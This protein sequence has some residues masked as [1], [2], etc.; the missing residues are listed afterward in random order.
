VRAVSP[1]RIVAPGAPVTFAVGHLGRSRP[2][3]VVLWRTDL[4][5]AQPVA[6]GTIAA[7]RRAW[8]WDGRVGGAPAP[9]GTYLAQLRRADSAGNLARVPAQIPTRARSP[10]APGVTVRALAA[11]PPVGPVTAGDRV[12]VDVDSRRRPYTWRLRRLGR[13]GTVARGRAGGTPL[14]LAA[15]AGRSGV[16]VLTLRTA[17]AATRVPILVQSQRRAKLLVVVPMLS[18]LAG[19]RVDDG[20]DGQ[21]DTLERGGPVR[22]PRVLPSLP[23]ELRRDVGPLLSFLDRSRVP[24]DLTSDL[25]LALGDGPRASDRPGVLL[26]GAERWI[27]LA[28]G[29]RLRRYVLDG[30]RLASIATDSLRR[31]VTLLSRAG[32]TAGLL[33][34]P[35]QPVERDPF[36]ER[37]A[38]VRALRAGATLQP[39]AGSATAPLLAY[40]DGSL[41][42][43]GAAEESRPPLA[44]DGV[45][46]R[47]G[48]GVAP[49][50]AG[51]GTDASEAR[52]ALTQVAVGRGTVIRIGLA[53]WPSRLTTDADVA[54]LTRNALDLL[55]GARPRPRDLGSLAPVGRAGGRR[56]AG[57]RA[58]RGGRARRG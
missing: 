23:A 49:G 58:R 31:G 12:A 11:Q 8:S 30:G 44:G 55:V 48:V 46:V 54:Q 26:A 50:S 35:T 7:G 13:P 25:A 47:A 19:A 3:D 4:G 51:A 9:P 33:A 29:R 18:W 1:G 24:Y 43:F 6:R 20:T 17:T 37:L 40:W 5:T 14:R 15:P 22:W 28:Y 2:T 21:P 56:G 53:G 38:P 16:Y 10:G 41:S 52:P 36:G 32:G 27:P 39:V 34:R 42:G 45:A 57:K